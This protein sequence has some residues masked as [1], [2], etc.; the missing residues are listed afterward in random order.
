MSLVP[1][2][3]RR[4]MMDDAE[5]GWA[6]AASLREKLSSMSMRA[7]VAAGALV[8][9]VTVAAAEQFG[10]SGVTIATAW[11]RAT[12]GGAKNGAVYMSITAEPGAGDR[13]VAARS[14]AARSV[15]LH[16][17]IREGGVSKMRRLDALEILAGESVVLQ[18]GGHHLMLLDLKQPLK[19]GDRLKLTLVFE[20]AGEI[21]VEASIN[22]IG[23]GS[24]P[25]WTLGRARAQPSGAAAASNS[26]RP[27]P[28]ASIRR[29]SR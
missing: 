12:P 3:K 18:P 2:E 5:S 20:K 1:V 16:T 25:P 8:A 9:A 7:L 28:D 4:D 27:S 17:S 11:T 10:S 24:P 13:L 6:S 15:E 14:D 21:T 29:R 23:S 19:A 26:T 22:A